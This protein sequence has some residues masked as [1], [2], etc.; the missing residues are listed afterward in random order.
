[1][2][3]EVIDR[4]VRLKPYETRASQIDKFEL[5]RRYNLWEERVRNVNRLALL[6]ERICG[7]PEW[8]TTAFSDRHWT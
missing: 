3:F 8:P 2:V 5:E 1:M 4:G 7:Y 6:A